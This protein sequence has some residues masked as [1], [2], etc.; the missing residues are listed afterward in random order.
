MNDPQTMFNEKAIAGA[1]VIAICLVVA[2]MPG[3]W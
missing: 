2:A 1:L 3:G